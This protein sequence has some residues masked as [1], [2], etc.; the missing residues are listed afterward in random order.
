MDKELTIRIIVT[1]ST[2]G[3]FLDQKNCDIRL[4]SFPKNCVVYIVLGI[5][6]EKTYSSMI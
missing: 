6:C 4:F 5:K 3:A 2:K 1:L